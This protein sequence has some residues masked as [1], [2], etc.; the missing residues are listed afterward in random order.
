M[1]VLKPRRF[2]FILTQFMTLNSEYIQKYKMFIVIQFTHR[3]ITY[4]MTLL[5]FKE[6]L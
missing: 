1:L 4:Q 3:G 5:G 2:T 6:G